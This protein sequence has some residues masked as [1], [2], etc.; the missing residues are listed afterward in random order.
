MNKV[1]N[2]L[3]SGNII[4]SLHKSVIKSVYDYNKLQ[5]IPDNYLMYDSIQFNLNVYLV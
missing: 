4:E 1:I 5:N 2:N 3:S